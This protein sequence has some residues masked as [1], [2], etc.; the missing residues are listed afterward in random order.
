MI[1]QLRVLEYGQNMKLSKIIIIIA[2]LVYLV[3]ISSAQT[4]LTS[5]DSFGQRLFFEQEKNELIVIKPNFG[6]REKIYTFDQ[7]EITSFDLKI[8]QNN[9]YLIYATADAKIFFTYS[10]NAG[11]SFSPAL[12]LTESG[13]QPAL[14]LS[15]E[16]IALAWANQGKI[17][18]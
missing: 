17:K 5:L 1:S 2:V 12:L 9:F 4:T 3:G 10:K 11:H 18:Y 14:A 6:T 13:S 7:P 8:S 16:K 15:E